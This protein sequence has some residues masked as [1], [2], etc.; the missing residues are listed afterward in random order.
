MSLLSKHR[1]LFSLSIVAIFS[2]VFCASSDSGSAVEHLSQSEDK[3]CLDLDELS[4]NRQLF[5]EM[6][7]KH[8]T[9]TYNVS[10]GRFQSQ[11]IRIEVNDGKFSSPDYK[12]TNSKSLKQ[13]YSIESLFKMAHGA[14]STDNENVFYVKRIKNTYS[15]KY[16]Y[17]ATVHLEFDSPEEVENDSPTDYAITDF[18]VI[19]E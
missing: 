7:P 13:F 2:L 4:R 17:P 9:Y 5:E 12:T 19:Q 16:G 8:Y 14:C 15:E 1:V 10:G 18:K 11:K 3:S 6:A